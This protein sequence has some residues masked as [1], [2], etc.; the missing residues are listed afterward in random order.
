MVY[1]DDG[2]EGLWSP[3]SRRT[4]GVKGYGGLWRINFASKHALLLPAGS[5]GV[6]PQLSPSDAISVRHGLHIQTSRP[7]R[8]CIFGHA[9]LVHVSALLKQ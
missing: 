7:S 6:G 1:S 9:D 5:L 3:F 8:V 2:N 4:M